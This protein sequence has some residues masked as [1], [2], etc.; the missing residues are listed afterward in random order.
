M[1]NQQSYEI[2]ENKIKELEEEI[3][4]LKN[5][6]H[7]L[8]EEKERFQ[9]LVEL[10][11][12]WVWETDKNGFYTYTD[13]KIKDFLGYEPVEVI[14]KPLTDF[15]TKKEG[16]RLKLFIQEN[17]E[18]CTPF[19]MFENTQIHSNGKELAIETSGI[20][21]IDAD[22]NLVGWRGVNIDITNRRRESEEKAR[23]ESQIR[24]AQKMEAIGTLAGGIAHEF[25][26]A[27]VAVTGNI[28]LLQMDLPNDESVLKYTESMKASSHR[29]TRLTNQLLAYAGGG[30]YRTKTISLNDFVEETLAIVKHTIEPSIRLETNLSGDALKVSADIT[31]MQ[32][33]FSA[34]LANASEAIEAKGKIRISTIMENISSEHVKTNPDLMPGT[35]VCLTI[36]DDGKGMEEEI[37]TKI[38]EPFFT[39]KFQGRGLGMAA[40]YGIIKN[41]NGSIIVDSEPGEGTTVRIYLPGIHVEPE[42]IQEVGVQLAVGTGTILVIEDEEIVMDVARAMLEKLG[43]RILEAETGKQASD[44]V[45]NFDGDIDLVL[46]DIKLP[47]IDGSKLYTKIKNARPD[48]KVIVCSG[49]ALDGPAQEIL[50]AGADDFIQKPFS[51]NTLSEK[52]KELLDKEK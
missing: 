28:E 20:P 17:V 22:G 44:I 33:V 12:D 26:N 37:R 30:K 34:V 18:G 21:I 8:G 31:Q 6:V 41:H 9:N 32:M 48:M 47:D 7:T 1:S 14:G 25:N 2:L 24:Q 50:D 5:L 36:E 19:S 45:N 10:T 52:L 35:Y 27:I 42:E 49:Y 43:Y 46:L 40:V 29:M 13:P 4:D 3:S 11:S 38:F 16:E 51:F 23:L 39:T 15:M